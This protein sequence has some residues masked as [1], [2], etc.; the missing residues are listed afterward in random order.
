MNTIRDTFLSATR[1]TLLVIFAFQAGPAFGV[2]AKQGYRSRV[3][4][5]FYDKGAGAWSILLGHNISGY[6]ND[7]G[8]NV[9]K[10]QRAEAVAQELFKVQ[11]GG[12]YDI[13][14][15][16]S[17][18]RRNDDN[19][20]IFYFVPIRFAPGK[21]LY[22][23]ARN[24]VKNDF[25]WVSEIELFNNQYV[26]KPHNRQQV[27]V[28][29]GFLSF[30]KKSWCGVKT[31]LN[32]AVSMQKKGPAPISADSWFGIPGA[33]YFY[34][35]GKPYY[36]FTNFYQGKP[37]MIDGKLWPT[38]EHYYQA[39]KTEDK[40]LQE[41]IRQSPDVRTVFNLGQ[42]ISKRPDW[43]KHSVN[44]MVKAVREKFTQDDQLNKLLLSTKDTVLVEAAGKRDSFYGAGGD[45][46]GTNHLGQ[47]LTHIRAELDGTIPVGSMYVPKPIPFYV[48]PFLAK[49]EL[50]GADEGAPVVAEKLQYLI[51]HFLSTESPAAALQ[52]DAMIRLI[53]YQTPTKNIM[54]IVRDVIKSVH[55][56]SLSDEA[57]AYIDEIVSYIN[58]EIT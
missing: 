5:V 28:S 47:I 7:F 11:T 52:A 10:G 29:H 53:N 37:V 49:K 18:W 26:L 38:T 16:G 30:F 9:Q 2:G 46:K 12:M 36:E 1:L 6:W 23:K 50:V 51:E 15:K 14:V 39:M 24:A 19:G 33:I 32:Q 20:D 58:Q 41:K 42:Q 56:E 57:E 40:L 27:Q 34:E 4:P 31:Q 45:W 25:V 48:G 21:E 44:Y 43:A 17:V 13:Q 8:T 22:S 54:T 3:V 55:R 35:K